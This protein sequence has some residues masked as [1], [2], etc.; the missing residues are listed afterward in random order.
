MV[1]PVRASICDNETVVRAAAADTF[2]VLYQNVGH[3]ALD[4]IITPLLEQ[5]TPEQDHILEGLC[6]VM[7]QNSRL[8]LSLTINIRF[9]TNASLSPSSSY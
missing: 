1:G 6:E 3:D 9:K 2:S 4:D 7:K 5:L 8:V